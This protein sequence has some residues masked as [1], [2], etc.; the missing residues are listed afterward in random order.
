MQYNTQEIGRCASLRHFMFE[1]KIVAN[2]MDKRLGSPPHY[3]LIDGPPMNINEFT[4]TSVNMDAEYCLTS[5]ERNPVL[6]NLQEVLAFCTLG[7]PLSQG[8]HAPQG[9]HGGWGGA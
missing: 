6:K 2:R 9:L 4:P 3:L 7:V 1:P 8:A 5:E